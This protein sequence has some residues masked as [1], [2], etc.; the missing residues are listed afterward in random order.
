VESHLKLD[1]M[2]DTTAYPLTWPLTHKR[3]EQRMKSRFRTTFSFAR[4]ELKQELRRLGTTDYIL[5][6]NIPVKANGDPYAIY[7]LVD[8]GI[9]VYFKLDGKDMII[10]CDKWAQVQDN[11]LSIARGIKSIRDM[12]RWGISDFRKSVFTGFQALPEKTEARPWWVVLGLT[13]DAKMG[14]C[15]RAYNALVKVYHPD[16]GGNI[17]NWHELQRAYDEAIEAIVPP[18]S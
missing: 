18:K 12:E 5:S 6:S 15:S 14:D 11:L 9:A 17:D 3:T 13:K 10:C 7:K 1:G 8:P 16:R 4:E 2:N